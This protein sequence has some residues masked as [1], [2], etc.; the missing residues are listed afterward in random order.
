MS[1]PDDPKPAHPATVPLLDRGSLQAAREAA[2]SSV[3]QELPTA[4]ARMQWHHLDDREVMRREATARVTAA[5]KRAAKAF[6][7]DDWD[8]CDK[9]LGDV[10]RLESHNPGLYRHRSY[11]RQRQDRTSRSLQD[12][13]RAI[14]LDP[15]SPRGYYRYGR[16]LCHE[17][18][19]TEAGASFIQGLGL[20]SHYGPAQRRCD[21]VLEAIRRE[22][23]YWAPGKRNAPA[24]VL[25]STPPPTATVPQAPPPPELASCDT[26]SIRVTWK[27]TEDDGGDEPY[28]YELQAHAALEEGGRRWR[29]RWRG[30]AWKRVGEGCPTR[31][32]KRALVP[33]LQMAPID[34][35]NP[36]A[37]DDEREYQTLYC[38]VGKHSLL[39]QELESDC[40]FAFRVS[41]ANAVGASGW[42]A[43]LRCATMARPEEKEHKKTELPA[44]WLDLNHNLQVLRILATSTTTAATQLLTLAMLSAQDVLAQQLNQHGTPKEKNWMALKRT[45]GAQQHQL[46][47]AFRL[48]A[49]STHLLHHRLRPAP[50][51]PAPPP[52]SPP[53]C[54][55]PLT[56]PP[57]SPPPPQVHTYR[58]AGRRPERHVDVAVP[59]LC[60][61][62]PHS[63]GELAPHGRRPHLHACQ[64]RGALLPVHGAF[65][66]RAPTHPRPHA[67]L[68]A[69][70]APLLAWPTPPPPPP[71]TSV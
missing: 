17:K 3:N 66:P 70:L 8:G 41:C 42:S 10:L 53:A 1:L 23:H 61:R 51:P 68:A 16:T 11:V 32:R 63:G 20:D 46:K 67:C 71:I 18:R 4:P 52:A 37:T 38:G 33:A 27:D 2:R 31:H 6:G 22:R 21:D 26:E 39:V 57:P 56:P 49:A 29:R 19:L 12:A 50:S 48:C 45:L 14:S 44:E 5:R 43:V 13:G 35:L 40:E 54:P 9:A 24:R 25:A 65:R 62:H 34:P 59:R 60:P 7:A 69:A 36:M 64:P 28:Q 30:A 15:R 55:S 47:L 58:L